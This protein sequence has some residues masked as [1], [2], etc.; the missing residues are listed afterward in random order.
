M[1]L[2]I[3]EDFTSDAVLDSQLKT[4]SS[5]LFLNSGTHPCITVQNLLEFLP[6]NAYTVTTAW[7]SG[8]TYGKFED[9]RNKTDLVTKGGNIYQ[10]IKAANLNQ[11]PEEADSTY[12][13]ETNIES[14]RLKNLI[15]SV[16]DKVESDLN[17]TNRLINNQ[18]IYEVGDTTV[19]L[20]NDYAAWIFEPKGSDYTKNRIN[21]IS[22]QKAGTTPISLYVINQGQLIDTLSI[23]PSNGSVEF[24]ALD[25]TFSGFGKW[26]FA[27]DSTS[28][29]TGGNY[30]DPNKYDGFVCYTATGTGDA[31]ETATYS[32]STSGNGL[33]F[34]ITTYL[35]ASE[36]ITNNINEFASYVK[37][38]FEYVVFTMFYHNPNNVSNRVQRIQMDDAVLLGELKRLDSDTV[39]KRYHQ[40]KKRAIRKLDKTFDTQLDNNDDFEIEVSSV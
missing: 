16:L 33:G 40:E 6:N 22:I 32:F 20:P 18:Y 9:S 13:V 28:V 34:N 25:Y 26:I 35:D 15:F 23:T 24:K 8:T 29:I 39:A 31:P 36:Y 30:V 10:S 2:G 3:A 5:G 17:L 1:I 38:A 21:K 27:I 37:A 7:S 14:L 19:T 4:S 12:W 11:D